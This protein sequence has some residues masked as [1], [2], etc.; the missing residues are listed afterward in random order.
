MTILLNLAHFIL[1]DHKF[2]N[3]E[4]TLVLIAT[5]SLF[6]ILIRPARLRTKKEMNES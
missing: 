6:K 5:F 4:V 3:N 1:E 2:A